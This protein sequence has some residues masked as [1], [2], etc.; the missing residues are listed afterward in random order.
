[1]IGLPITEPIYLQIGGKKQEKEKQ[2]KKVKKEEEKEEQEKVKVK[3][4]NIKL[5]NI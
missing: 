1:M 4:E 2:V 5:F 3:V